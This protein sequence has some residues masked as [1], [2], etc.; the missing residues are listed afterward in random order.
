M[1]EKIKKEIIEL[2]KTIIICCILV[3][4]ISTFFA[5]TVKV[6]GDSMYPTLEDKEFGITNVFSAKY[7]DIDR[8]DIVIVYIDELDEY[9]VKRVIG[10][11][12]E[13][14]SYHDDV[15]YI[16][17]EPVEEPFLDKNYVQ[18]QLQLY[19]EFTFS[20]DDVTL[21]ENEYFLMGD[22]RPK[23]TDSRIFEVGPFTRDQIVGKNMFI[24][25]PF[26]KI[27]IAN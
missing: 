25:Y 27:K 18:E 12:G 8:F 24:L 16:N 26:N 7:L 4:I 17:H 14:I 9:W 22:N 21:K 23:S 10:L 1:S 2:I 19:D 6:S 20:F 15:L 11:P 3:Y 13:T 5:K